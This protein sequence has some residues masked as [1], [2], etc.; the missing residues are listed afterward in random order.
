MHKIVEKSAI[1]PTD[2]VLEIG[3]GTGNLTH[4][5]L[6]KAKRVI[7]FEIDPRMVSELTKRFKY[8]DMGHKFELIQGKFVYSGDFLK[9]DLP[10]F[11]VCVA[12]CPYQISSSIVFKLLSHRPVFRSATLMF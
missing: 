9:F 1:K 6:E 12:N 4:L 5:L 10:Y 3:P 7:C 2:V 11:D 8:G